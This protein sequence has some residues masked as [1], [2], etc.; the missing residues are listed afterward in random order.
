M[1]MKPPGRCS[2][3]LAGHSEQMSESSNF[4]GAAKCRH[5]LQLI[6]GR[7]LSVRSGQG[8]GKASCHGEVAGRKLLDCAGSGLAGDE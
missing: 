6:L 1:L 4:P 7:H 8:L 3:V 2:A 5:C